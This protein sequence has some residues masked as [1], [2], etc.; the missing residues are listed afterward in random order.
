MLP[1]KGVVISFELLICLRDW[2]TN[3]DWCQAAEM[4]LDLCHM[5]PAQ[6]TISR[7][8]IHITAERNN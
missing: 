8:V 7:F 1:T 6:L 3:M 2:N 5:L 4:S